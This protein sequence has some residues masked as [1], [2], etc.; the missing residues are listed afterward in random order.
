MFPLQTASVRNID[1]HSGCMI[2][3]EK[4][5]HLLIYLKQLRLSLMICRFGL[6]GDKQLV[7]S[8]F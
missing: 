1:C 8:F 6:M 5:E 3:L 4:D 7:R 2:G